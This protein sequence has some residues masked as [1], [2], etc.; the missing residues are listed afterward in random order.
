MT[1]ARLESLK[2]AVQQKVKK[3]L[4]SLPESPLGELELNEQSGKIR[5]DWDSRKW[6]KDAPHG[7][8]WRQEVV[9]S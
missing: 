8:A 4:V 3:N 9:G 2:K 6:R 1:P 7:W 5:K